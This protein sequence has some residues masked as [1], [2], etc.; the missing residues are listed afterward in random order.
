MIHIHGSN[1]MLPLHTI[2]K[3]VIWILLFTA[4]S[5]GAYLKRDSL[6]QTTFVSGNAQQIQV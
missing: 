4:N 1:Q 3:E 6:E 5:V 2:Y